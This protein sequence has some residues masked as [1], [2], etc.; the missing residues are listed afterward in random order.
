MKK[1]I[2]FALG[3]I[4]FISCETNTSK[5]N[6]LKLRNN[7]NLNIII[8]P[9]LS[10]RVQQKLYPKPVK[11]IT[12]IGSLIDLYYP[13]LYEYNYR[14]SGQKDFL[15]L[16]FT[17]SN[18]IQEYQFSGINTIDISDKE[19]KN[20]VYLKTFD[21]SKTEFKEDSEK[22]LNS[23]NKVYK[24][25]EI[26]PAGADLLNFLKNNLKL[27]NLL[28]KDSRKSVQK[29]VVNTTYRNILV[30]FT[31]GYIEAG[32]YG[33]ENCI[34]NKCYFLDKIMINKFRKDYKKNSNG[35]NL[36]TFFE[37]NKYGII[38]VKNDDL[39]NLEILVCELYDR[40]LNPRTGSQTIQ[41]NDLDILRVFWSDW[42]TKSGVKKFKLCN[43]VNS[44][45]EFKQNL[46]SFINDK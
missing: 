16:A 28:K 46:K 21:G 9:D 18:I 22:I 38:P 10:N 44:I 45:E 35:L 20:N 3:F 13:Y 4:V 23:L 43:K 24:K 36:K 41:P 34:E 27:N 7:T 29:Y 26:K 40:S 15:Q 8:T 11:D 17:N 39:K 33:K 6:E 42:L 30:L 12:L 31:D 37:Q 1:N 32:L 5:K 19:D 2:L 14:V 25:V